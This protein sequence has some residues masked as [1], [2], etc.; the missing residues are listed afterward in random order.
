MDVAQIAYSTI[1]IEATALAMVET[2][3]VGPFWIADF[4]LFDVTYLGEKANYDQLKVAFAYRGNQQIELIQLPEGAHS[5][6]AEGLGSRREAFHHTYHSSDED[7]DALIARYAANGEEAT[8][9]GA[10]ISGEERIRFC[11]LDARERLGHFIEL[12]ETAKMVGPAAGVLVLY[13]KMA[14]IAAAWDGSRP[15]RRI[16]ELF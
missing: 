3:G 9:H 16:E 14:A 11:Y 12:L 2:D 6:Y 7:Y 4:P 15:L 13:E 8:Y 1:D 5:V 10:A